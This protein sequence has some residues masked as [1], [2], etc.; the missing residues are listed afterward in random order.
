MVDDMMILLPDNK[1]ELCVTQ[2]LYRALPV[3]YSTTL[4][5]FDVNA[6]TVSNLPAPRLGSTLVAHTDK[7]F[8]FFLK[9]YTRKLERLE[10]ELSMNLITSSRGSIKI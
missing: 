1:E 7:L 9:E 4:H 6:R 2:L 10:V 5:A 3:S 8:L